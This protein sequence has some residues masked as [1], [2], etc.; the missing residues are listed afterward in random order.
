MFPIILRD[1][2]ATKKLLEAILDS[3]AG[4]RSLS[5]L[6]R[7]C[8][9]FSGPAL[10]ILWRE[11]DSIA[12]V[13]GLFP[14]HLLKKTR[15]PGM[16]LSRLP[17]D[18]DWATIF[19]YSDRIQRIT[20]DETANN[21]APSIFSIFEECRPQGVT[22]ILPRLQELNWKVDTPAALEHATIFIHPQLQVINL[23]I[24][25]KF[26]KINAF[27][28]DMSSRTK[29]K[30]S[31]TE[32]LLRQDELEKVIL[33]APGALGP[34]VGHWVAS[35]PQLKQL[36]L[37]L[38]GRSPIAVEGFFD[39]LGPRSGYSTPSSIGSRD[40]G[41][42]SGEEIDFTDIR[43][44]ALR[45]TGD[46]PPKGFAKLKKLHLTGEVGNIAVFLKHIESSIVHLDLVIDDP[47]DKADWQ[48]LSE[49]ICDRFAQ[50][51]QTLK[52]SA[53]PS[54]KF[55]DLVRSTSRAEPPSNRLS[56]EKFTGLSSLIRLDIDLPESIM[57]TAVDIQ[58]LAKACPNLESLKLCPLSRFPPPNGPKLSLNALAPLMEHCKRLHTLAVVVNAGPGSEKVL[59]SPNISSPSLQRLHVGHSWASDS[60][61]ISILLSHIMPKLELLK[62]FQ[63]KNRAGFVEAHAKAWQTVS[64]TMPHIQ[65][66]R[67]VEKSFAQAPPPSP[68]KAATFE[69]SVDATVTKASRGVFA[70][71]MTSEASIQFSPVLQD[72]GVEAKVE[73]SEISIDATPP[74]AEIGVEAKPVMVSAAVAA[75]ALEMNETAKPP[76][77]ADNTTFHEP[78][79]SIPLDILQVRQ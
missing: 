57:F 40:S 66:L 58:C 1:S 12:P 75:I 3:P 10:D 32:L 11:L 67:S 4:R 77:T 5:R 7:T 79:D 52:I 6:A 50:S 63:E 13:V 41:V 71:V 39:E 15:K 76:S 53:T 8:H 37:D 21:I 70:H 46:F 38:T 43:K 45:L 78:A 62:W 47:P 20:Y 42:F 74:R 28:A 33:V 2:E 36:Q 68:Q 61:Q 51:L 60:L 24:G 35:L 64:E 73:L 44:S 26:A 18:E 29:L 22:Y 17:R 14:G 56:L 31:F 27:L 34:G 19:K 49:L 65:A 25:G 23:E 55:V 54:S 48:D 59:R 16:G 69:K 30:D 72:R 9:A